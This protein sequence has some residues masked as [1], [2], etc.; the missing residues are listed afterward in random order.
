MTDGSKWVIAALGLL[1][2]WIVVGTVFNWQQGIARQR[3]GAIIS[4]AESPQAFWLTTI[5]NLVVGS[6]FVVTAVAV[7]FF[8]LPMKS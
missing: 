8:G 5:L 3:H 1:G 7:V 6:A 4:R 2:L